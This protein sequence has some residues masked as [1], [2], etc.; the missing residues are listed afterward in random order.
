MS[1]KQPLYKRYRLR[2]KWFNRQQTAQ[3]CAVSMISFLK[4]LELFGSPFINWTF[5]NSKKKS[6][7]IPT[8]TN[9]FRKQIIIP[10]G[11][12]RGAPP[13]EIDSLGFGFLL[14]GDGKTSE[15]IVLDG[16][17]GG[18]SSHSRLSFQFPNKGP[19]ADRLLQPD[20]LQQLLKVTVTSWDPDWAVIDYFDYDDPDCSSSKIPVYWFIYLSQRRG[21][22]PDL[23]MCSPVQPIEGLGSY[24][25]V[26]QE[27]FDREKQ[28]HQ[29]ISNQVKQ[30]LGSADLLRANPT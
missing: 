3:E 1:K 18:Y 26:T 21:E 27:P 9:E 12:R 29:E 30:I 24:V 20:F 25:I 19:F 16:E 23:P 13:D 6:P 14:F 7:P 22:I 10:I 11:G 28:P 5:L 17:C 15:S 4:E 2:A 8:E